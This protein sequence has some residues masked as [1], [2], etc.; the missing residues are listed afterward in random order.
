M[1]K[2]LGK[3]NSLFYKN[4]TFFRKLDE[5]R[6]FINQ[7]PNFE[8]LH[9]IAIAGFPNVGKSTLLKKMTGSDVE[10][11]NYPFTTKGLMFGYLKDGGVKY[12]QF[13]DTPGLL[14]RDKSNGIEQ[15]AEVV[16]TKYSQSIIFV[17]DFTESSGYNIESQFKLLKKTEEM[18]KNI[19]I[20]LSKTDLYNEEIEENLK[21]FEKK[22]S[23]YNV[24]KDSEVLKKYC[25][26]EQKKAIKF[27]PAK[28]KIIR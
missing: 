21:S 1:K 15:R 10:I 25:L 24:F 11:Q 13:I 18:Q 12:I 14:G 27:D 17:I 7:L 2:Y 16:I 28:L 5:A 3:V 4:K 23:K 20:Y 19:V 6:K 22:L 26:D 9:T 8:D